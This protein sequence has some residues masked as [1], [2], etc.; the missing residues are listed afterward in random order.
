MLKQIAVLKYKDPES[1]IESTF[2]NGIAPISFSW[3]SSHLDILR[4][5]IPSSNNKDGYQNIHTK[6][7]RDNKANND[8]VAFTTS[9]NSSGI[10]ANAMKA[11]E[12]MIRC[13]MA[14]EY[15]YQYRKQQNWFETSA[16]LKVQD[17]LTISI[18]EFNLDSEKQTHLY[19]LPLRAKTKIST[20]KRTSL[21]LGYSMQSIYDYST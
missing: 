15:P 7:I 3:N 8:K 2:S 14:I 9:F 13:K 1:G 18:P 11:G 19:L 20:N 21:K 4:T 12:V 5:Y 10:H 6:M 17:K 16:L